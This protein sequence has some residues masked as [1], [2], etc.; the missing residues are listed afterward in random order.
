MSSRALAVAASLALASAGTARAEEFTPEQAAEA[1]RAHVAARVKK[2]GVFLYKDPR[3]DAVLDLEPDGVRVARQIEPYGFFVCL[4]LHARGTPAKAYD[5]DFWLKPAGD[6][7]EIVDARIHK[8][9][10]RDGDRWTLVTRTPL[11]WWWIPA[12]EH[13]GDFEEK[14]GWQVESAVHEHIARA[15]KDGVLHVRDEKSGRDLSLEFVEIHKPLRRLEGK[16]YFACSDF[17]ER[18]SGEKF[19]DLDF[20]LVEKDGR[21]DVTEVRIHKEPVEEDGR[22]VQVP[23][24]SFDAGQVKEV[25]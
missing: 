16:G 17:R 14:R 6:R 8:A 23:R 2:D 7:L 5:L 9:P 4:D 15:T 22:W 10:P 13:P 20:W 12:T 24:Y 11:L 21:L 19:Y 25:P 3:A 1:V 18:G